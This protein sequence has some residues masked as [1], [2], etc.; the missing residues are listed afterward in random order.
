MIRYPLCAPEILHD[1]IIHAG[2][3]ASAS[4]D[5]EYVIVCS[6]CGEPIEAHEGVNDCEVFLRNKRELGTT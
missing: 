2:M 6:K 3:L 5:L 1:A 4:G